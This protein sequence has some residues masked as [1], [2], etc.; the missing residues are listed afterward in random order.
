METRILIKNAG[1]PGS[2][3]TMEFPAA[4]YHELTIGRHTSCDLK[5]DPNDDLVSRRHAKITESQGNGGGYK[6][7]DLGSRNGTFVNKQRIFEPVSLG[8][9]DVVQLGPG[10]P[11]FEFDL[12][13]RPAMPARPTRLADDV[14]VVPGQSVMGPTREAVPV[15]AQAPVSATPMATRIGRATV[16][17]M[18]TQIKSQS[19]KTL[20]MAVGGLVVLLAAVATGLYFARPRQIN[21]YHE[22]RVLP[23]GLTPT[24][25]SQGNTDATVMI[26][27]S[28]RLVDMDS[29]KQLFHVVIPNKQQVK[30]KNGKVVKE[31][32]GK[33]KEE[34]IA[35]GGD[36]FLPVFQQVPQV[37]VQ[38]VLA[39]SDG[40]GH[41]WPI[42]GTHGGS[43]FVVT[44][45]GF[46]LTNRHVG[47]AWHSQYGFET[48][49]VQF[50]VLLDG[51]TGKKQPIPRD[52]FAS[53]GWV[54]SQARLLYDPTK[55]EVENI[56]PSPVWNKKLE[57]RNDV[58]DIS[59]PHNRMRLQGKLSRV[60]DRNDVAMIKIDTPA[61][62][63]KAELNDNWDTI[64]VG[65]PVVVM[66]YPMVSLGIM[67]IVDVAASRDVLNPNAA[68]KITPDATLSAGN[69]S[70]VVRGT[71]VMGE[72]EHFQGDMYQLTINST[73]H[74]N[75]GGPTFDGYGKVIGIFTLAWGEQ[76]GRAAVS[77]SIPIRYGMELMGIKSGVR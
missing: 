63:K 77:A 52:Y 16:E 44:S 8:C 7:A 40:D 71:T 4:R 49:K 65:D 6:I 64:K 51:Q 14:S 23:D 33:P 69:V 58:L 67:P 36:Q 66:G 62:L 57:G 61:N 39:T 24:Q 12:D 19:R 47:A 76:G 10:G 22:T 50:G 3:A 73:G 74:G 5:F 59:F 25:I 32:D 34:P 70:R 15:P 72:G 28:W 20:Y 56:D 60:S 55:G 17:R 9:G 38:P 13:P 68:Q 29:G 11:Q 42:G 37:G 53:F 75:S 46:I 54:P 43:G 1:A 41:Y 18:V 31:K 48:E 2:T 21:N 26:E 27:V 45:D 35:P 30:D